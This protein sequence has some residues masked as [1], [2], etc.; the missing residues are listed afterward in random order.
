MNT[1]EELDTYNTISIID[2]TISDNTI[3]DNEELK[4][5]SK[6]NNYDN[7]LLKTI[8]GT[9]ILLC[10]IIMWLNDDALHLHLEYF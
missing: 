2:N 1:E 7:L 10:L 3:S 9:M 8:I 6:K 4:N 5:Q